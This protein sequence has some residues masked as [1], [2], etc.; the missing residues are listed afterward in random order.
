VTWAVIATLAWSSGGALLAIAT[1]L[2]LPVL[3]DCDFALRDRAARARARLRAYLRFRREPAL[4]RALIG[5]ISA[6][7]NDAAELERLLLTG[8]AA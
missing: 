8:E 4:Q 3:A 2:A 1:V 7:R 6:A 5:G